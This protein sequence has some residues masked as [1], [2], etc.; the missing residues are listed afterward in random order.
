MNKNLTYIIILLLFG[1]PLRSETVR[2]SIFNEHSLSAFVI[3]PDRGNYQLAADGRELI[4]ISEDELLYVSMIGD[5]LLLSNQH[6]PKGIFSTVSFTAIEEDNGFSIRPVNPSMAKAYYHGSLDLSVKFERI[7]II[8]FLSEDLY[9]AGV[10]EA[11]SGTIAPYVYYKAQAI[12]CR[13]YLYGNIHRHSDEGFHLCDE[14]HCQ[15]YKGRLTSDA[16]IFD[17]VTATSG[18]VI[19]YEDSGLITAAFH[20]NCGGQTVNSEAVWLIHRHYLRSVKDPYCR[21][22]HNAIWQ[23]RLDIKKWEAYLVSL[24][25]DSANKPADYQ[26]FAYRQYDRNVLYRVNGFEIPFIKLRS[27]WNFKSAYFDVEVPNP[28]QELVIRGRGYG[29]GV[30][31]CQEGAMEMAARGYNFIEILQFYYTNV[32]VTDID[33]LF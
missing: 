19:T 13:T 30:G 16:S 1:S 28:G 7:N 12:I 10:V 21:E 15:V 5:K 8:N 2:V 3:C 29:H 20:S 11:E 27:D 25:L 23:T 18:K 33:D 22:R 31:L 6:G 26:D 24:G 14:V 9:L 17:A 4:I 32:K